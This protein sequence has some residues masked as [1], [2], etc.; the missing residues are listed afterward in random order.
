MQVRILRLMAYLSVLHV[1]LDAITQVWGHLFALNVPQA[2]SQ[3]SQPKRHV[4][5]VKQANLL[6]H[7]VLQHVVTAQQRIMLFVPGMA[8]VLMVSLV[9]GSVPVTTVT[10]DQLVPRKRHVVL[11]LAQE[12]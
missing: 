3:E 1:L 5:I 2:N 12:Q 6:Q 4:R 11:V 7:Q 10:Q 8:H 9:L